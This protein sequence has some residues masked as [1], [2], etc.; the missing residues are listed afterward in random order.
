MIFHAKLI[1]GSLKE[2][3]GEERVGMLSILVM[4]EFKVIPLNLLRKR[5]IKYFSMCYRH[6]K[7]I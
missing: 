7:I 3:G 1:G 2:N 6:D 5:D 4:S